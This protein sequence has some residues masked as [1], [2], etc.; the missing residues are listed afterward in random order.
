MLAGFGV[1]VL[2]ALAVLIGSSVLRAQS[3]TASDAPGGG[4]ATT[5]ASPPAA[6]PSASADPAPSDAPGPAPDDSGTD[7][8]GDDTDGDDVPSIDD[9]DDL[10]TAIEDYYDLVPDDTDGAW[11]LMTTDYQQNH[12]E[13]RDSYEQFW[14]PVD[15]VEAED[16]TAAPPGKVQARIVYTYQDG[17][18]TAEVTSFVLVQEDGVLKVADSTVISSSPG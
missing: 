6:D 8:T 1:L 7:G 14:S 13:G 4:E 9:G 10:A 12:A 2:L 18:V 17:T 16:I 3:G 5:S 15:K 11:R